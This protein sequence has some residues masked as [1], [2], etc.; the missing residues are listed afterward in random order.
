MNGTYGTKRPAVVTSNDI[1]IFY[2]YRPTRSSDA[3]DFNNFKKLDSDLLS[4][5]KF[6]NSTGSTNGDILP[7]MYDMRLPLDVFSETG[8]YTVYIK[9]KELETTIMDIGTLTAYPSIN[10]II[11]NVNNITGA[12]TSFKT[13]NSLV[14]YCIEFKN[15]NGE[16]TNEM[17]LITSNNMCQPISNNMNNA[18]STDISYSLVSNS[19]LMFCTVT[20][21]TSMSFSDESPYIG[22]ANQKI[23][24]T[25]TKFNP[26]MLEI[27]ITS[28]DLETIATML[29]GDQ[30]RNL[31]KGLITTFNSDGE[32]YHQAEYG[33]IV[34][35]T[36]G[37]HHDF[38][39]T[40][41]VNYDFT[42]ETAHKNIND[43]LQ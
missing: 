38:R 20:P 29:E 34:N 17:R 39:K 27:E 2:Y 31:D 30:I 16:R 36:D 32:M 41:N 13:N 3:K 7:G 9:P 6:S 25:N 14:G 24:L 28:H 19:S 12:E 26:V 35:K 37:L 15:D 23:I 10:G 42:E 18:K 43:E 8:I 21:S 4:Q 33:T 1:D 5:C 40:K 11:I 22:T